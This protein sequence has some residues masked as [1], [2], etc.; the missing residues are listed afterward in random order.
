MND[1]SISGIG[2]SKFGRQPGTTAKAMAVHAV[3]EALA[4]AGVAWSDV[5]TVF[6]GSQS[7]GQADTLVTELGLTGV[8]FTTV[9]N[10]CATGGS[11][12]ICAIDSIRSGRAELSLVVGFDKHS[13]GG[14][15]MT[16]EEWGLPHEYGA[17]GLMAATQFFGAKTNRYM[18]EW[19]VSVEALGV[20]AARAYRNGSLNPNAWRRDG[21]TADE[22]LSADLVS[23]P[24]TKL[25]FCSPGEGAVAIVLRRSDLGPSA[26]RSVHVLAAEMRSRPFGSFEVLSPAI[27]GGG[28]PT[29]VSREAAEAAFG[30]AGVGRDEIS[31]VQ[32]QDTDSGME[33]IHMAECG[34]VPDGGQEELIRAGETDIGGRLPVNTDGGCIANGEPVAA[35][36]LRQVHEIVVQ[37]RQ[38]AGLRQVDS[39]TLGFTHVYGAPGVSACTVLGV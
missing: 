12:L 31:V 15:S 24:L 37:L 4:D 1:V 13:R 14:F 2:I 8:P 10:G 36:G 23:D 18:H 7:S 25:M 21:V 32:L 3:R 22:V 39:P 20:A 19:G 35:S 16:P 29:S 27:L 34:F 26:D 5:D 33:M 17:E 6:G 9:R 28:E 38:E 30:A 11:A